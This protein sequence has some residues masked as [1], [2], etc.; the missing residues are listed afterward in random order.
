MK[1]PEPRPEQSP[2]EIKQDVVSLDKDGDAV[3]EIGDPKGAKTHK[4]LVSTSVLRLA[5]PVFSKMFGPGFAEGERLRDDGFVHVK[6]ED[7]DVNAMRTILEILHHCYAV[8]IDTRNPDSEAL[9]QIAFCCDKY[10]CRA[11]LRPWTYYWFRDLE[12][13]QYSPEKLRFLLPAAYCFDEPGHFK[14]ISAMVIKDFP[15]EWY[16]YATFDRLSE[17]VSGISL[18]MLAV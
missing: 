6:L 7:D 13:V 4:F 9:A 18:S 11:A 16:Q 1:T 17:V 3:I 14:L 15:L 12:H 10:D 8:D 5:S 2:D